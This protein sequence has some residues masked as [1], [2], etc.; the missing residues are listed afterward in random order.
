[1]IDEGRTGF[2]DNPWVQE[3]LNGLAEL[4]E[5]MDSARFR[6]EALYA[7]RKMQVRVA[8][9]QEVLS[10]LSDQNESGPS[11]LRRKGRQGKAQPPKY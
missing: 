11:F 5:D 6:K 8:A 4:A 2:A 10:D 7:S 3:V 9:C 1:M